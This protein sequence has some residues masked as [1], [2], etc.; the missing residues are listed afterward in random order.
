[1]NTNYHI[2]TKI[3][4]L[5]LSSKCLHTAQ[6][7]QET[8]D[9][10]NA[11]TL[12]AIKLTEPSRYT[13]IYKMTG[14]KTDNIFKAEKKICQTLNYILYPEIEELFNMTTEEIKMFYS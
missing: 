11:C 4:A 8:E 10:I 6:T 3:I 2:V 1:M 14:S 5:D 9:L 7:E 13:Q 12:L